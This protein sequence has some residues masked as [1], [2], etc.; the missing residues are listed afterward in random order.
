L[1]ELLIPTESGLYCKKGD[2]YIDPWKPVKVAL[3]THG[4]SDHASS[5]HEQY[6]SS[7][8]SV[9]ILKRRLG[10]INIS[11]VNYSEEIAIKGVKV[12]FHPAGHVLGS[13][14]IRVDDGKEVWVVSGVITEATFALPIYRWK[15]TEQIIKEI[16]SWVESN[17]EE[18]KASVLFCYALGKAQRILAELLK[19]T[20]ESVFIH[21]AL[22]SLVNLYRDQGID[23]LPTIN[24]T[25]QSKGF[26]FSD[27]LILAPPSAFRSKWMRRF[28][29]TSTGFVSGWMSVRAQKTQ[30]GYDRGFVLSDHCD[31]YDLIKTIKETGASKVYVTHGKSDILVRYLQEELEINASVLKTEFGNEGD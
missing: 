3:I 4:H 10:E 2:F 29:D 16:Y 28:G 17:R 24:A 6:Y 11:G 30:G 13:A 12:S 15:P 7:N 22:E 5:G 23:M 1:S 20:S 31:W 8:E 21:G 25:D 18:K 14:Q 19:Y 26:D 9:P 27:K